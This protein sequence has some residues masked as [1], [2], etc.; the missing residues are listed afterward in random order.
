M[1]I[2]GVRQKLMPFIDSGFI[3]CSRKAKPKKYK[4]L[5]I[6]SESKLEPSMQLVIKEYRE[7]IHE[8]MHNREYCELE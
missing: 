8:H 2:I 5:K 6:D 4:M 7:K 1:D 3:H